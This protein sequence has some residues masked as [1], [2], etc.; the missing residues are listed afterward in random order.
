M[1]AKHGIELTP[2]QVERELN[3]AIKAVRDVLVKKGYTELANAS[4]EKIR[5]IIHE[6]LDG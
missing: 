3:Q 5:Q 2:D 1:R 4:D 6:A